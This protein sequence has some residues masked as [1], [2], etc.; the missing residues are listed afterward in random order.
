M[1]LKFRK[2]KRFTHILFAF[3]VLTLAAGACKKT[4]QPS[5]GTV[6][7]AVV[8]E[9]HMTEATAEGNDIN[10]QD[11]YLCINQDGTFELYQKNESQAVR[12]DRYTGT[13]YTS[14]GVI[15][16]EYSDGTKWSSKW[17][18]TA[19]SDRL[20]LESYNMLEVDTYEKTVIPEDV[21]E[22]ANTVCTK[23][24]NCSTPIL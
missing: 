21:R 14:E 19:T 2:M 3:A 4:E 1:A 17:V 13:C 7:P 9:W 16:G 6:D 11:V 15:Y 18:Y 24:S 12:Y 10:M 8:G 23:A 22:N 5:A 20:I